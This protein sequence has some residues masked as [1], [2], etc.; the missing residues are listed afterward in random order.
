MVVSTLQKGAGSTLTEV[1]RSDDVSEAILDQRMIP[2]PDQPSGFAIANPVT[3]DRTDLAE[4]RRL[5]PRENPSLIQRLIASLL[6]RA[7]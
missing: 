3:G 5:H 6:R 7:A 1:H 2:D 4:Y